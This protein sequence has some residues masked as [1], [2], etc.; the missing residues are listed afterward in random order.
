MA[1][2]F[3]DIVEQRPEQIEN[4]TYDSLQWFQGNVRDIRRSP[5]KFLKEGQNF[6]QRFELGKM[7]M[8][9]Y[10]AKGHDKLKYYDTFPLTI[11]VRRYP[12]GFL[13]LNL[14]Y[15]APRYRALLMDGMYD[16]FTDYEGDYAFN[17]RYPAVKS[18]SRL[19][20][21][22]PCIKQYQY[23]YLNSRIVEVQPEHMDLVTMLP[24]QRFVSKGTT[25][26]ANSIYRDSI[27]KIM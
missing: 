3:S 13:G 2:L 17:I 1:S 16:F 22:K 19:R 27:G 14:H 25:Y 10:H 24:S 21:A 18:V 15:I 20:W 26:N 7:Y 12:T 4:L 9:M 11:C 8:F 5:E 6:V 23:G